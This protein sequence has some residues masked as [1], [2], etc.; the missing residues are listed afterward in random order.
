MLLVTLS[1][2]FPYKWALST[3]RDEAVNP[4]LSFSVQTRSYLFAS[5]HKTL[6]ESHSFPIR[7]HCSL[8]SFRETAVVID[9]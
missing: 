9:S 1:K 7:S 5:E 8:P 3:G 4:V 2:D 6:S